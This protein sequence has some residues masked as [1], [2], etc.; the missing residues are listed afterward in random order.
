MTGDKK[1]RLG[2]SL[3]KTVREVRKSGM[4]ATGVQVM[5]NQTNEQA[6]L[7]KIITAFL[8]KNKIPYMITGAW[9]AIYYGRPRASHDI[10]FVIE[11]SKDNL[12]KA[13]IAFKKLPDTFFAQTESIEEAI[14]QKSMFNVIHLPT[15][16]KFDFW[17]LTDEKFDQSRF[18]RRKKVKI[19][20]QYMQMASAEDTILQKL[21]WYEMGKI[22]KH[23]VDAVF[24]YQI[25]KEKLDSDYLIKWSKRLK[26]DKYLRKLSKIDLEEYI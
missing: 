2:L 21:K 10:D 16:L 25:Q 6:G 20:N 18:T 7:L 3:S 22:E 11:L 8:Q 12:K 9:S 23:L 17:I 14:I 1:I 4:T 13:I 15:A 19:L 24:V 26:L 5:E